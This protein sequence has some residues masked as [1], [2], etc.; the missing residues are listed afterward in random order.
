MKKENNNCDAENSRVDPRDY[1]EEYD[2]TKSED[3]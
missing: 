3:D 1:T 2:I